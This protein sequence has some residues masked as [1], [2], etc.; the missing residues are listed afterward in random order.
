MYE[1]SDCHVGL[2]EVEISS[3]VIGYS[4]SDSGCGILFLN[5]LMLTNKEKQINNIQ[6]DTEIHSYKYMNEMKD[7]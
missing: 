2:C 3:A 5:F 7:I 4:G 6:S 1:R